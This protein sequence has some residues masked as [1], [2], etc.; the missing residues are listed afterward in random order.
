MNT[1]RRVISII[2]VLLILVS[3]A[4]LRTYAAEKDIGENPDPDAYE[5]TT[6]GEAEET[7]ETA[8]RSSEEEAEQITQEAGSYIVEAESADNFRYESGHL[9]IYGGTVSV[10]TRGNVEF[11]TERIEVSGYA[12]L[13]LNGVKIKTDN[14]SA[15][16]ILPGADAEIRLGAPDKKTEQKKDSLSQENVNYVEGAAGFAAIEA[17]TLPRGDGSKAL[18]SS[19]RITGDGSLTAVGGR[20]AAAIGGSRGQNACGI[21]VIQEGNIKAVAGIHADAIGCGAQSAQDPVYAPLISDHV[22]SLTALSDGEGRPIA[23]ALENSEDAGKTEGEEEGRTQNSIPKG[24]T[25]ASIITAT[26]AEPGDGSLAGLENVRIK[27]TNGN[28]ET[29]FD[30]PEGYR[31]FAVKVEEDSACMIEQGGRTFADA[32]EEHFSGVIEE[33]DEKDILIRGTREQNTE[34]IFL[35]PVLKDPAI[36]VDITAEWEDEDNSDGTRPGSILVTLYANGNEIG[37]T[38]TLSE[39]NDWSGTFDDLPVYSDC[40][41][42]SYSIVEERMQGYTGLISGSDRE[43]YTITNTHEPLPE[44]RSSEEEIALR[45]QPVQKGVIVAR[46]LTTKVSRSTPVR[47]STTIKKTRSAKTADTSGST[48][49][50]GGMLLA[51]SAVLYIWMKI[52]QSRED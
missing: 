23:A 31:S 21:I 26:F 10:K 44:G 16:R 8:A 50:W 7:E 47:T 32:G 5:I 28:F 20:D 43:G 12:V 25:P 34:R 35:A 19:L 46:V 39:E 38:I 27:D 33:R 49:A 45:S 6:A 14:G 9:Y 42:Q 29:T 3:T 22:S 15:I 4:E 1:I 41:R 37:R 48:R 2:T 30:M 52:E 40:V 24:F 11:S 51:A 13:I 18:L 36:D 17:G